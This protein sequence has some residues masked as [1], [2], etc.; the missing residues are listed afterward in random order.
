MYG[1]ATVFVVI[2]TTFVLGHVGNAKDWEIDLGILQGVRAMTA[3]FVF[4]R[5]DNLAF[6]WKV[7]PL[8]VE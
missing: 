7:P 5:D 4:A 2:D 6:V 8:A 3:L 1:N